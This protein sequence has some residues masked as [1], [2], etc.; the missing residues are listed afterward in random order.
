MGILLIDLMEVHSNHN[1]HI[2]GV[3]GNSDVFVA[4]PALDYPL[5]VMLPVEIVTFLDETRGVIRPSA[6]R[7]Q[8]GTDSESGELEKWQRQTMAFSNMHD[9]LQLNAPHPAHDLW[10]RGVVKGYTDDSLETVLVDLVDLGSLQ[11]VSRVDIKQLPCQY[12]NL[13]CHSM[14]VRLV[15]Q[16]K[17]FRQRKE[18]IFGYLQERGPEPEMK[19]FYLL[20]GVYSKF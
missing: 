2:S 14:A 13:P 3:S 19:A 20:E 6:F 4:F 11:V 7:G 1:D 10:Y 8:P 17:R 9:D 18:Q 12:S 5:N 15:N 16:G